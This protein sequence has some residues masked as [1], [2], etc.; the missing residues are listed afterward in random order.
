MDASNPQ[1]V[2]AF[3][4][5][6]FAELSGAVAALTQQVQ[7]LTQIVNPSKG[8]PQQRPAQYDV[9]PATQMCYYHERY[10][11]KARKCRLPCNFKTKTRDVCAAPP[12][13]N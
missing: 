11:V 4:K 5:D 6:P 8:S 10:G 12:A 2:D 9:H 3:A 13:E 7:A 1:S